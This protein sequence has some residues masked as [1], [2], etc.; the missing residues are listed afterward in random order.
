VAGEIEEGVGVVGGETLVEKMVG[1]GGVSFFEGL[2][3]G[4]GFGCL[5]AGCAVDVQGVADDKDFDFVLADEAGNRFE[6]RAEGGAVES[7]E[8]LGD[9]AERVCDRETDT[10]V[11]DVEREGAGVRH[12]V[13][14]RGRAGIGDRVERIR[15]GRLRDG[16][17]VAD[18]LLRVRCL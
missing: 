18:R 10:A 5:G 2:G 9:E 14:V 16:G 13:S 8:G 3:E 17:L 4:L 7:E 12:G 6:I 1:E 11:T 15:G